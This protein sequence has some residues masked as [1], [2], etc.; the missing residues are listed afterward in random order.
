MR[1]VRTLVAA[2]IYIGV[3]ESMSV[4]VTRGMPVAGMWAGSK[5]TASA[6]VL[7]TKEISE[8]P[9]GAVQT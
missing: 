4:A 9:R 3:A 8:A 1:A 2:G 5:E 6:A 7:A